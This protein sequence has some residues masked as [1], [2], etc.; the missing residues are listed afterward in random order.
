MELGDS[1]FVK[2]T[3]INFYGSSEVSDAFNGAVMI[4]LPDAPLNLR[5]DPTHTTASVIGLQWDDG[6]SDGGA[7]IINYAVSY[8]Q[9]TS[10]WVDLATDV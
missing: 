2:V 4:V 3:A 10:A 6:V 1:V 8:D 7:N 5:D 9:G